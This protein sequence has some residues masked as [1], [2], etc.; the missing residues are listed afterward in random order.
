MVRVVASKRIYDYDA[1]WSIDPEGST[2]GTGVIIAPNRV[3]TTANVA[4]DAIALDVLRP[5]EGERAAARVVSIDHDRDLALLEVFSRTEL[6]AD[7]APA[8][9]GSLPDPGAELEMV[10]FADREAGASVLR[11][12]VARLDVV[13]FFHAQRH[14]PALVIDVGIGNH[15]EAGP[16]F[17]DGKLVGLANQKP[18]DAENVCELVPTPLIAAFLAAAKR[19]PITA[20][21]TLGVVTQNLEPAPLR[22]HVGHDT[23]VLVIDVLQGESADGVLRP[24]DVLVAVGGYPIT[25]TGKITLFD[26]WLRH[27]AVVALH[28]PGDRLRVDFVRDRQHHT[29]ELTLT[30]S[31]PLVPRARYDQPPRYVVYAGLVFQALTRNYLTTWD[32]WWN[33]APKEFLNFYYLGRRTAAQHEVVILSSILADT[34]TRGYEHLYNEAVSTIDGHPPR[35]M[36]DFAGR[37]ARARGTVRIDT[38]SG[39]VIVLDVDE[40]RLATARVLE[41]YAI[42]ADRTA[43]LPS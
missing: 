40:A 39:G 25:R 24:G 18:T 32:E 37:L 22:A 33:K 30:P 10:G 42:P 1:P 9:L 17:V 2:Y 23:G 21:P 3:L 11:G 26:A 8:E 31:Q 34:A 43:G 16:A 28:Q 15:H 5:G 38:T 36:F 14:L 4:A 35:D 12:T 27:D 19:G 7:I 20:V 13:R 6:F 41:T 29:A